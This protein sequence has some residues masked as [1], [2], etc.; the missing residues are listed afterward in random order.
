MLLADYMKQDA[1]YARALIEQYQT[2]PQRFLPEARLQPAT[3][4]PVIRDLV[5]IGDLPAERPTSVYLE[6]GYLERALAR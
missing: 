5:A 1:K 2:E 4:E 3:F 6:P